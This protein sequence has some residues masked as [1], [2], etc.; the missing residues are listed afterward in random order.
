MVMASH[1]LSVGLVLSGGGATGLT[2]IGV[3]KA[4]EENGVPIDYI[5]GSSMGALVGGLYARPI[6]R[7]RSIRCSARNSSRSWPKAASNLELP[8][9]L[10]AGCSGCLSDHLETGPGYHAP[11]PL[12]PPTCASRP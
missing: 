6:P 2:H 11:V 9:L 8:L 1:M 10:Q 7:G 3:M 5:T 12:F 4:L